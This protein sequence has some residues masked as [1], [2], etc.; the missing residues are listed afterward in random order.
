MK[1]IVVSIL[2]VVLSLMIYSALQ[3]AAS[4]LLIGREAPPFQVESGDGKVLQAKMLR[5]K[6]VVLF[7]ESKDIIAK[8]R[9]LKTIL[10]AFYK[11]QKKE[12]QQMIMRVPIFDCSSASW[13]FKGLWKKSLIENSK[14][15]GMTVYGDWDG[16]MG[17]SYGMKCDDTNLLIIDKRGIIRYFQS[18][19]VT[20][21]GE[22]AT[23]L[24]KLLKDLVAE[25][26]EDKIIPKQS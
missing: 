20:D 17:T 7:Y 21:N 12:D 22:T 2:T 14:R 3:A 24:K 11:E 25:N 10:N 13:P 16:K 9:P 1:K 18:G 15:V 19:V 4:P 5:G 6:V 23:I 26:H 8:S